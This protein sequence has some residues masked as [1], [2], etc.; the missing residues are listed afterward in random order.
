[1][2]KINLTF[3][4]DEKEQ[5]VETTTEQLG[6]NFFLT[7]VLEDLSDGSDTYDEDAPL[8]SY[9]KKYK[10]K[11]GEFIKQMEEN[12]LVWEYEGKKYFLVIPSCESF[13]LEIYDEN[14]EY[15]TMS[16]YH[17]SPID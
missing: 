17:L 3:S 1:M 4:F 10:A 15:V 5:K 6:I 16:P 13:Y 9:Q 2:T 14:R 8:N 12:D 7:K 11:T